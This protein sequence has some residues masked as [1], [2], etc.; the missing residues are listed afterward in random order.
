MEY[1]SP[2]LN[3]YDRQP[4]LY[5]VMLAH[6]K[7]LLNLN[8]CVL[9]LSVSL[10]LQLWLKLFHMLCC[11]S[12]DCSFDCSFVICLALGTRSLSEAP[13]Y[14]S[15]MTKQKAQS[16]NSYRASTWWHRVVFFLHTSNN[17]TTAMVKEDAIC[18]LMKLISI[19]LISIY[20]V[21]N[22]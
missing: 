7:A 15:K 13:W 4:P 8:N 5:V 19:Y 9:K 6:W 2:R 17:L 10:D 20:L 22:L 18:I 21:R 1:I 3:L 11:Y 12:F 16:L 14:S